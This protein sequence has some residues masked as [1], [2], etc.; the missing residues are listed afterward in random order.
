MKIPDVWRM[1]ALLE[2]CPK[3]VKEQMMGLDEIPRELRELQGE[4]GVMHD[5]QD[6]A[7]ARRTERDACAD[8]GGHVSASEPEEEDLEDVDE[9]RR[10]SICYNCR[11]MELFAKDF[12]RKGK[13][14][15]RGSDG[16]KAYAKGKGKTINGAWK[17]GAN[18]SGGH[19]GGLLRESKNWEYQGRCLTCGRIGHTSAECLWGLAG[20][21]EEDYDWRRSAGQSESEEDGEVG[22]VW[23]V[24]NVEDE[25]DGPVPIQVLGR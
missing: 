18:I 11:M 3:N 10:R 22:G 4:S 23:I 5:Q 8:G 6:R 17:T 20:V 25:E 15:G 9:V 24:G 21:E 19:K 12:R 13:G 14:K 16:S 1:S 2:I 7:S